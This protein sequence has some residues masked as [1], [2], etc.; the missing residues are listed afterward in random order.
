MLQGKVCY[1]PSRFVAAPGTHTAEFLANFVEAYRQH[2]PGVKMDA[3][4]FGLDASKPDPMGLQQRQRVFAIPAGCAVFW[5]ARL[6]HGQVKTPAADP[7]EYGSVETPPPAHLASVLIQ[8]SAQ[9]LPR[10]P[11]CRFATQVP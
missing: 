4:K 7:I 3:P 9:V 6:L 8:A 1:T 10:L 2:Y 5:H 11:R